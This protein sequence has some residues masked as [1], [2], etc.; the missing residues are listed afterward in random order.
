MFRVSAIND[1]ERYGHQSA[2]EQRAEAIAFAVHFLQS[3]AGHAVLPADGVEWLRHYD[4]L[5]PGTGSM[6]RYLVH[7]PAYAQHPLRVVLLRDAS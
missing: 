3:T 7:R 6:V 2:S 1:R 4:F 5:I